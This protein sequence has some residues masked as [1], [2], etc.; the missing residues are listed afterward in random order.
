MVWVPLGGIMIG[1]AGILAGSRKRDH[2]GPLV[3]LGRGWRLVYAGDWPEYPEGPVTVY[4][5]HEIQV[6][7]SGSRKAVNIAQIGDVFLRSAGDKSLARWKYRDN[8][9]GREYTVA[10]RFAGHP[11]A[12]RFYKAVLRTIHQSQTTWWDQWRRL[13]IRLQL[14]EVERR[15]GGVHALAVSRQ[16]ACPQCAADA[17]GLSQCPI[18]TGSNSRRR[19]TQSV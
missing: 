10:F 7:A 14:S 8:N 17:V 6:E 18:V 3:P 12:D 5:G 15:L 11:Q 13:V 4:I 16:V 9:T 2:R 19:R 1:L